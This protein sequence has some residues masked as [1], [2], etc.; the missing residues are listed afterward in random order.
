M[1]KNQY[2]LIVIVFLRFV[3]LFFQ[4]IYTKKIELVV[5]NDIKNHLVSEVFD[6]NNFSISDSLFFVNVLSQHISFFY[7]SFVNFLVTLTQV[8]AYSVYLIMTQAGLLGYMLILVICLYP[9]LR[10]LFNL[11]RKTM[12]ESY[13]SSKE[14]NNYIQN[15]IENI[16][17]IK[18]Y[19]K[20]KGELKK[21]NDTL[22]ERKK[23]LYK[24]EIYSTSTAILPSFMV[25]LIFSIVALSERILS[26]ITIDFLGIVLRLFQSLSVMST[27][28]SRMVNSYVHIEELEKI[29]KNKQQINNTNFI[30]SPGDDVNIIEVKKCCLSVF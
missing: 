22:N 2:F 29:D 14:A 4:K 6:K 30:K 16:F 26:L 28:L 23:F 3:T 12:H 24:N 20:G 1:K 9:P 8:L 13:V 19:E 7:S 15:I 10:F 18:L 27:T 17:L 11:A 21:I 5:D 25:F